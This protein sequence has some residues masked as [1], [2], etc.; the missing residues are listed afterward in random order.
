MNTKPKCLNCEAE[1]VGRSDKKFCD[2]QCRNNYNNK[3]RRDHEERIYDINR[4][5]RKNRSLLK[6]FN[7]E[8]KTT[9]RKEYLDKLDFNFTYHTH[10]VTTTSG[11]IYRYCYDF[12]YL[13]I[14]DGKR[15]LI[16]NEQGYTKRN[17]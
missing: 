11:N 13:I 8:G 3:I 12:G 4:I 9:I 17:L 6:K 14:E 2:D 7:P 1:L 16:V 5:L 10:T 15:V